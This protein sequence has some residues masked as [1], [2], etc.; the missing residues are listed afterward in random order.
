MKSTLFC[1]EK[2][3]LP[4]IIQDRDSDLV[5]MLGYMNEEAYS[6]TLATGLVHFYSRSRQRLWQKGE[7]SGNILKL[8]S[9]ALDCDRDTLLIRAKAKGPTCHLGS[10]SCFG[11]TSRNDL[12]FL[13]ELEGIIDERARQGDESSYS[14][15]LLKG[16]SERVYQKLGEEAVELILAFM[17]K[18]REEILEESSDLIFHLLLSLK[19]QGLSL[20][21]VSER[22]KL[23]H[24]SNKQ[25]T[26]AGLNLGG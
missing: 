11:S 22:L 14:L 17:K 18:D 7:S 9:I 5:L 13:K 3:L 10:R 20:G 21:D 1:D 15:R 24:H 23:R 19:T 4:A 16:K 2:S 8:D 6:K 12:S 26:E 25:R